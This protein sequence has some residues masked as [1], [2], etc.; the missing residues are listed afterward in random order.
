MVIVLLDSG[1]KLYFIAT[2]LLVLAV[3]LTGTYKHQSELYKTLTVGA[4]ALGTAVIL[5]LRPHPDYLFG[6]I[7]F[8]AVMV[9]R[10]R[11][12]MQPAR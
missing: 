10:L 9:Y 6:P 2:D 12:T 8:I 4:L 11:T 1:D 7:Y 3:V 5:A